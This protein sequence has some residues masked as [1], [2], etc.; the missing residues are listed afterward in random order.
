MGNISTTTIQSLYNQID[1]LLPTGSSAA[2]YITSQAHSVL[3]RNI[4]DRINA[5]IVDAGLLTINTT[6]FKHA[7]GTVILKNNIVIPN[8]N[9]MVTI[10]PYEG[11]NNAIWTISTKTPTSF[12]WQIYQYR[13]N[14]NTTVRN[15]LWYVV[16]NTSTA[17]NDTINT[18][19]Q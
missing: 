17:I 4:L 19:K 3:Q 13:G 14:P 16:I 6:S 10:S 15:A 7:T 12:S 8:S 11:G 2:P 9:Y 5:R 18:N 1:T